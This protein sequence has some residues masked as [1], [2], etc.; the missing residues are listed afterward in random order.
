M[1]TSPRSSCWDQDSTCLPSAAIYPGGLHI[2]SHTGQHGPCVLGYLKPYT[3]LSQPVLEYPGFLFCRCIA[4]HRM[5][6][7]RLANFHLRD[8][9]SVS[10]GRNIGDSSLVCQGRTWHL[11]SGTR[12]S[13]C[14]V[15]FH[16]G[17]VQHELEGNRGF[18]FDE[19][20][21]FA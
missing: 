8:K 6:L 17:I 21:P 15:V 9:N 5:D 3:K 11:M 14:R 19:R 12:V 4:N 16:H 10:L 18:K 7:Q 2:S 13:R 1:N 20:W